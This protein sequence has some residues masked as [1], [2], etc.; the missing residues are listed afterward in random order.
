M[1]VYEQYEEYAIRY[2]LKKTAENQLQSIKKEGNRVEVI[3][4]N[5]KKLFLK[6]GY[7]GYEIVN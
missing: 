4:L 5:G 6:K 2:F 1:K 7:Y 3:L